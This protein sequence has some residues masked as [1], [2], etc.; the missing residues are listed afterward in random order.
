ME[1]GI[2][3]YGHSTLCPYKN[4]QT[5][6]KQTNKTIYRIKRLT[7]WDI[8]AKR[9]TLALKPGMILALS[10]PLGAGKT[11][12]VQ[13]LAKALGAKQTPRSPTFSLVRTYRVSRGEIRRLVHADAYRIEHSRDLLALNLNEE[14]AEPGTVLALE[15]P[16][17]V[18]TWLKQQPLVLSVKLKL[19]PSGERD[20]VY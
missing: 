11:T 7:D 1:F 2:N 14:L 10:G 13:A 19:L 18:N 6:M 8:L 15:W 12:F 16:E 3:V 4:W 9:I 17:Q 20:V 5:T